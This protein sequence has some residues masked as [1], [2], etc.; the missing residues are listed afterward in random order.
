M[1]CTGLSNVRWSG[2]LQLIERGGK[3]LL[4]DGAHN[5]GGAESLGAALHKYFPGQKPTLILGILKDKD[6]GRICEILA[7]LA[8]RILL[9][10]VNSQRTATTEELASACRAANPKADIHEAHSLPDAVALWEARRH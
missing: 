10:P 8:A 2:R 9:V 1:I 6:L 5:I 4:L 3:K 7:P